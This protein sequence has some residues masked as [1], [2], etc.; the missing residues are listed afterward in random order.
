MVLP[1]MSALATAP[2]KQTTN[3]GHGKLVAEASSLT[4]APGEWP[5]FIA[6]T[7]PSPNPEV[8]EGHLFM[9]GPSIQINGQFGGYHYFGR[10][11]DLHLVVYND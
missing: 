6:L 1:L 5:D 3:V 9:R 7:L 4:L 2:L 8:V 10:G 11:S